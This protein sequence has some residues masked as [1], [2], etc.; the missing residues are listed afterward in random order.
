MIHIKFRWTILVYVT[1][2]ALTVLLLQRENTN[3]WVIFL[4][5]AA[6]M[7][8]FG[9]GWLHFLLDTQN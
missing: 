3:M 9:T 7:A 4:V 1:I 5:M 2:L 8:Q 6:E